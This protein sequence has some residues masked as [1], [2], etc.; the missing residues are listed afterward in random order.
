MSDFNALYTALSALQA[1]QAGIDTASHNIS[2]VSTE[3]FTRQRVDVRT[4]RPHT[5]P[6]GQIGNGVEI[7]D[8]T[9]ARDAH[10]DA[11]VRAGSATLSGLEVR[12]DVLARL[13]TV[14]NEPHAGIST[15]LSE[16]W[17]SFEE[18]SLDP[19]ANAPRLSVL[20]ALNNVTSEIHIIEN[21]WQAAAAQAGDELSARVDE[22]NELLQQVADLNQATLEST[23]QTGTPNDLLDRRDVVIDRLSA[24]AGVTA[25]PETHGTVR[26]SLNGMQLVGNDF[27]SNPSTETPACDRHLASTPPGGPGR[28]PCGR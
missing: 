27:V 13:E 15:A 28:R 3:G 23:A 19:P 8:I 2:N 7:V 20:N 5:L 10:M 18:W 21:G 26:V 14:M 22:F 12:S 24:L 6:F 1:S 25:T 9:R 17:S 4:R 11:R 16:L